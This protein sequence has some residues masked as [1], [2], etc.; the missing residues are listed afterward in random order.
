M[1]QSRKHVFHSCVASTTVSL[2]SVTG[3]RART[4]RAI[5]DAAVAVLSQNSGASLGDIAAAADVGRTTVHRYFP[6]RSDLI[7]ALGAQALEQVAAAAQRARLGEGPAPDAIVRLCR[8]L[9]E[10]GDLLMIMIVDPQIL[11]EPEWQ[12]ETE[13]DRAILELVARGQR[14]GTVDPEVPPLW[15]QHVLWALLYTAWEHARSNG[16]SKHDA[17]TFCERTLR[18]AIAP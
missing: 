1:F 12:E 16:A 2:V 6:E 14:E 3:T 5:L 7:S 11:A 8:E 18:R 17:L 10:L 4:R 15:V 9:F 13:T